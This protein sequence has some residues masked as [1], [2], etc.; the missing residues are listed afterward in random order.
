MTSGNDINAHRA[1]YESFI[2]AAT[3]GAGICIVVVVIVVA[4]IT[5]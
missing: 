5:S 2:K 3:W 4:L 1:T